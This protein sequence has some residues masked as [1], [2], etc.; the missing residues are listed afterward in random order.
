MGGGDRRRAAS[1]GFSLGPRPPG[2]RLAVS[3]SPGVSCCLPGGQRPVAGG[4]RRR[5]CR[6]R[7]DLGRQACRGL[8]PVPSSS[9]RGVARS[10]LARGTSRS[11]LTDPGLPAAPADEAA[12]GASERPRGEPA[13]PVL[14]PVE[15]FSRVL[16]TPRSHAGPRVRRRPPRVVAG[17][18]GRRCPRTVAAGPPLVWVRVVLLLP[19]SVADR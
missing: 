12:P 2:D 11:S 9:L 18:R 19:F 1:S 13:P 7:G 15:P 8:S 17:A 16:P 3:P 10:G 14:V 5:R 6:T 4:G